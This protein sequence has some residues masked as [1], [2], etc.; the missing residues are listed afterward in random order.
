VGPI[1]PVS[2][3][4]VALVKST[5]SGHTFM[6]LNCRCQPLVFAPGPPQTL[7]AAA[8]DA[9]VASS[10]GGASWTSVGDP[11][12]AGAGIVS[13]AFDPSSAT[14]YV[15]TNNRGVYQLMP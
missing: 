3:D 15:A 12:P 9:I 7:Y 1:F 14:L 10:D 13:M 11:L 6:E 4:S 5:D 8:G 2:Y